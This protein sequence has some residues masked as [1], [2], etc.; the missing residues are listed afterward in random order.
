MSLK[1]LFL[2][3][4]SK[5]ISYLVEIQAII[6]FNFVLFYF[7]MNKIMFNVEVLYLFIVLRVLCNCN[8][9]FVVTI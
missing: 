5:Y 7:F 8:S 6:D 1:F 9:P 2:Q 3:R 4:L